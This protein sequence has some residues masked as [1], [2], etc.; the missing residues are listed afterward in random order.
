MKPSAHSIQPTPPPK[1][2]AYAKN[3]EL[4]LCDQHVVDR[5]AELDVQHFEIVSEQA[6]FTCC[7]CSRPAGV[8]DLPFYLT[9]PGDFVS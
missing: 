9:G 6:G 1:T 5:L 7:R 4:I 2:I 8:Y 3:E